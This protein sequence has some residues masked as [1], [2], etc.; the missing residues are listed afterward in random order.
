M[1]VWDRLEGLEVLLA[2]GARHLTP[3]TAGDQAT[4]GPITVAV[5]EPSALADGGGAIAWTAGALD[6]RHVAVRALRLRVLL[7]TGGPGPV[8]VFKHGHQSWSWSGA[9]TLGE[10]EDPARSGAPWLVRAV[11]DADPEPA[12][13]GEIRSE[14]VMVVDLGDRLV[15][16]GAL[17]GRHHDTTFRVRARPGGVAVDVEAFLGGAHV[18]RGEELP[19]EIIGA[20]EGSRAEHLLAGWA[21]ALAPAASARAEAPFQVGWCS[22]YQWFE[23]VSDDRI[24]ETVARADDWPFEVIQ[25]DDGWQ[26]AVGDWRSTSPAFPSGT[27]PVA[28][29]IAAAGRRPGLWL[30]PFLVAPGS[31]LATRHPGWVARHLEGREPLV[32]NVNPAWGGAVHVLDTTHPEVAAHLSQLAADLVAQ[33]FSYLKLDFCYAPSVPGRYHD[34]AATPA[35]RVRAGLVAIRRGAGPDAFLLGC[36]SPLVP[37]VGLVDGMRIGPDVAPS[38]S[39]PPDAWKF[40]GYERSAPATAHAWD[41]TLRRAWMHRRLWIN[42]PDCLMLRRTDTALD[43]ATADA[44]TG[45]VAYSGGMV[46]ASDDLSLLGDSARRRLEGVISV[47][48]EVDGAARRGPPPRCGELMDDS[49]PAT[50]GV[51]GRRIVAHVTDRGARVLA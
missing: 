48:R 8:R 3:M 43:A 50:L 51:P 47:G 27:A 10:H 33:G 46:V 11:Y 35:Q 49:P 29:R 42:D 20:W 1:A 40:P 4:A 22:W 37:A 28:E 15:C 25:V 16:L 14:G 9:V 19:L 41:L 17:G 38:W 36:G 23:K 24:A 5:S 32:G 44:W 21:A 31:D 18:S 12:E 7:D 30:A 13:A 34:R 6:R 26:A 2:D 45:A 39:P